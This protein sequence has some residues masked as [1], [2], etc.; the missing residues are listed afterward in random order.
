MHMSTLDFLMSRDDV[1]DRAN[2]RL[3]DGLYRGYDCRKG[4]ALSWVETICRNLLAEYKPYAEWP[5]NFSRGL[6]LCR[7]GLAF[8]VH[9]GYANSS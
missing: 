6:T 2:V 8:L 5:I 9:R 4:M 3:H 7:R 1:K